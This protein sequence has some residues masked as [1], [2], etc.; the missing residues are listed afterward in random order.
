MRGANR[1]ENPN[2]EPVRKQPITFIDET[3]PSEPNRQS[4][5]R[6]V[7]RNRVNRT[8]WSE[9]ETFSYVSNLFNNWNNQNDIILKHVERNTAISK[10]KGGNR[11]QCE[12]HVLGERKNAF[13]L[14]PSTCHSHWSR[15]P[16]FGFEIA[17]LRSTCFRIISF[18]L[19][20]LLNKFET[21]EKVSH[22]LHVVRFTR[23][24]FTRREPDCRFGS[25]GSVS[26]MNVIGCFRTGS[27]FGFSVRLAPRIFGPRY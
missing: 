7:N 20:Q 11:L 8:T 26:S 23:F 5:S 22:S 9:C 10:P 2:R 12:W 1:T 13:F 27:R 14:S 21:Y 25:D 4:G 24:R 18:W 3:E 15:F 16:P 19:F 6:R 17:V